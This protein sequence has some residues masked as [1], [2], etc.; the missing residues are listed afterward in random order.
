MRDGVVVGGGHTIPIGDLTEAAAAPRLLVPAVQVKDPSAFTV[1]G[2]PHSR[3]DALAMVTGRMKYTNDLEPVPGLLRA[4]VRHLPEGVRV[5]QMQW[6][7]LQPV[8]RTSPLLEGLGAEPWVYFVHSYVPD[9]TDDVAATCDYGGSV[10]AAVQRDHLWA[11]QF[12]PEK[13]GPTG[14]AMLRN[15]VRLCGESGAA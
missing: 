7:V 3:Q 2:K 4:M 9:A 1:V 8:K 11:T 14:M 12:H 10:V 13:S 15:F 5:P 6:N